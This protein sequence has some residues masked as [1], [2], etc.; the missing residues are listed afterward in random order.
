L[1]DDGRFSNVLVVD[2]DFD[3]L[4]TYRE[5]LRMINCH[6]TTTQN[7]EECMKIYR[8]ELQWAQSKKDSSNGVSP[9]NVVILDYMMPGMNGL[10]VAKEILAL[11]PHQRIIF[12]SGYVEGTIEDSIK[13]LEG[14]VKVIKKPFKIKM[15]VDLIKDNEI[16][17]KGK[18]RLQLFNLVSTDTSF[19]FG[20]C[21]LV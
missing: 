2:D 18:W 16:Y 4:K 3:I 5:I 14:N 8:S 10:E 12:V 11:V 19:A 17:W 1:N 15:L 21:N 20:G 13:Q 6:V 9:F 7:G